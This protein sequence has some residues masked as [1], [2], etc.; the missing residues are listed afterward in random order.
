MPQAHG[1]GKRE[2][3]ILREIE[4]GVC[5]LVKGKSLE[6]TYRFAAY[7]ATRGVPVLCVS[8]MHPARLKAT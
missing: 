5:Y 2:T 3:G 4:E 7:Y 1:D 6:S 8:R